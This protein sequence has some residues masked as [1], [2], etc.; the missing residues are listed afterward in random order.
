MAFSFLF[1][2]FSSVLLLGGSRDLLL[3]LLAYT[4][5]GGVCWS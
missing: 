4:A 2:S 3:I 1:F 5:A